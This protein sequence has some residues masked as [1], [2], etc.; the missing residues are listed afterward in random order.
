MTIRQLVAAVPPMA[1]ACSPPRAR[2]S[3]PCWNRARN[4]CISQLCEAG[5]CIVGVVE[6]RRLVSAF[7]NASSHEQVDQS[8]S[9]DLQQVRHVGVVQTHQWVK[10]HRI[11]VRREHAVN[12]DGM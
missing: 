10:D 1:A 11:V 4:G 2:P 8:N 12:H 7:D 5:I 9:N 6:Q 3:G